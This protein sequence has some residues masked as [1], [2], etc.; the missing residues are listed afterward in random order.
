MTGL[1]RCAMWWSYSYMRSCSEALECVWCRE[2]WL[3]RMF[4]ERNCLVLERSLYDVFVCADFVGDGFARTATLVTDAVSETT[5]GAG[6]GW[7]AITVD[8]GVNSDGNLGWGEI[9]V[10]VV[11][12]GFGAGMARLMSVA[13]YFT[14]FCVSYPNERERTVRF[15]Y[16]KRQII[17]VIDWWR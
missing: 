2:G 9:V 3:Y 1:Y 6:A 4:R 7:Y 16:A 17:S 10:I 14:A 12:V 5:I 8:C 11:L 13:I 15:G